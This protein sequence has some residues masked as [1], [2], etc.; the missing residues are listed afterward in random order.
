[1]DLYIVR[2]G[3]ALSGPVDAA[4][5]L[6]DHGRREVNAVA[7]VLR[8][9]GVSVR[10]IRHSGYERARDTASLIGTVLDP[11]AGVI[12][13][14]GIHPDDPVAP[15]ALTLF[16]ERESLMLVGHLPFVARLVG[17]LTS[18]N[19][20]RTPVSFPTATVACLQGEDD[21]WELAWT[22]RAPQS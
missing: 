2:H 13:T 14:P 8:A 16:G 1:M 21:R 12:E 17:M 11:P 4:R 6:S 15:F 9:R 5:Q 18:G 22:E 20:T 7:E 19:S 10:Q 3:E